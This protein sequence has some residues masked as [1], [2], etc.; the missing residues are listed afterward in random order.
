MRTKPWVFVF[1]GS[2]LLL[3][4]APLF[5]HHGSAAYD[6]TKTITSKATVV[7]MTWSN[8]HCLLNFDITDEKGELKHWHVEMYNPLYM[9]RAGWNRNILKAGDEITISFH[10][11]RNETGN[12]YIR[13]GDGKVMFNG[14]E[15]SLSDDGAAAAQGSGQPY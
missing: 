13:F 5:A 11:A 3:A 14:K 4:S 8:P 7:D 2:L 9:T 10:P 6:L 15:L 12:G 1:V